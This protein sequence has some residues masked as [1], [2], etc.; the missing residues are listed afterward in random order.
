MKIYLIVECM[1]SYN[2]QIV[3]IKRDGGYRFPNFKFAFYFSW[4]RKNSV[5]HVK[6]LIFWE[7]I[8]IVF[9]I[10]IILSKLADKREP[11]LNLTSLV[12][13]FVCP[14]HWYNWSPDLRELIYLCF[15]LIWKTFRFQQQIKPSLNPPKIDFSEKHAAVRVSQEDFSLVSVAIF[16]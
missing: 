10:N 15:F 12:T 9:Q 14:T 6:K 11:E 5:T 16:I 2:K 4:L 8:T 13:F 1:I 3:I 7:K